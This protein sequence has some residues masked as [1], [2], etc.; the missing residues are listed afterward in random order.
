MGDL[1]VQF[2]VAVVDVLQELL[3]ISLQLLLKLLE[4][5]STVAGPGLGHG[6]LLDVARQVEEVL[7]T[8]PE[9]IIRQRVHPGERELLHV[10]LVVTP[11]G[12]RPGVGVLESSFQ[13]LL[14]VSGLK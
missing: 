5:G 14:A 4:G 3:L 7:L 9:R 1:G 13:P 11:V 12:A 8:R 10:G 6:P 2:G